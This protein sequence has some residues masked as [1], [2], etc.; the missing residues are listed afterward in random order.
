MEHTHP[1]KDRPR[2]EAPEPRL[3]FTLRKGTGWRPH[4]NH[5][6]TMPTH[7]RTN[8]H[9]HACMHTSPVL[10]HICRSTHMH[11]LTQ[12]ECIHI[13]TCTPM[14]TCLCSH[15]HTCTYTTRADITHVHTQ[16]CTCTLTSHI[17]IMHTAT[18][19]HTHIHKHATMHA[20]TCTHSN[21]TRSV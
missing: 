16:A 13:H 14:Q 15:A 21:Q 7:T 6:L 3:P 4:P 19:I 2:A 18:C 9:G 11:M 8:A 1:A 12:D 10:T 17:Q 20:H 5:P